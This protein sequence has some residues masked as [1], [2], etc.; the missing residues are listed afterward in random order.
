MRGN[1]L[2]KWDLAAINEYEQQAVVEGDTS[3]S[4]DY[5]KEFW[6]FVRPHARELL[7]GGILLLF[8]TGATLA[9]PRLIGYVVDDACPVRQGRI[10]RGDCLIVGQIEPH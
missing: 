5:L 10:S 8:T 7:I 6:G 1:D 3:L 2:S 4:M 9:V